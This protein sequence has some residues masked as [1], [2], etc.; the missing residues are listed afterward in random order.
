M[1]QFSFNGIGVSFGATTI[2][3][4]VTF[5]VAAG[6]KW[7]VIGRNGSGKT[8]LFRLLTSEQ[9]P[10]TGTIARTPGLRFALLDQ[11]RE[12][13]GATTVWGAVAD[14]FR[15][16]IDLEGDLARQ[17]DAL[18][19]AGDNVTGQQLD[20]YARDLERFEHA[21]GY[22]Y[23]SRVDAVLSG[24]GFDPDAA[25]HEAVSHLSGGERGRVALAR[26]LVIPADVML[27]DEPTNHLDLETTRWLEEYLRNTNETVLV[28]SHDRA[29]LDRVVDHVL[30]LEDLTA[31]SYAGGYAHFVR[32]R[33]ERR[34]SQQRAFD[35]QAKAIA[36]EEDY[37]RRNIAGTNSRQAKG[38]RRRLEW[39][40]RL[41]PPPDDET[42]MAVRFPAGERGG[43]QVAVFEH[44]TVTIGDRVLLRD[45][46]E[47]IRRGDVVGL[48]G[49]NGSGKST[50][51]KA[52]FG[53][54]QLAS[55]EIRLGGGIAATMYRQDFANVPRDKS[56]YDIIADLRPS[57]ERGAVQGHLGMV[58]FSGDEVM[59]SA[60]SLS[61]GELAR[62]ALAM[63]ML[64]GANLLVFDEP[65]N[66][67]DVESIEQLEDA[68][69]GF[70]GT[71]V[72]VSH[73]RELLRKLVTRV[74]ELR[75]GR[76]RIFDGDYVEF[77]ELRERE[78]TARAARQ[79]SVAAER[80]AQEKA[81]ARKRAASESKGRGNAR[82]IR[83]SAERAETRVT[84]LERQVAELDAALADPALYNDA[85]GHAHA[86]AL[87][88]ELAE[89]HAALAEALATWEDAL[90]AAE[91]LDAAT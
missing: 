6:E 71:V 2:L 11:H 62:V 74:W 25:R 60:S 45:F 72:L 77:E 52:L 10:T 80:K 23:A 47:W 86:A 58:Q 67:L 57:W 50:L 19:H 13:A 66:H 51:L 59:R 53:E 69:E 87:S 44:V 37:I 18:A 28:I 43:D 16:L 90:A 91:A 39:L 73:D 40:P 38:R 8:T 41:S 27:L 49:P 1:T 33:A 78:E 36:K 83:R 76:I 31:S 4:D 14:A 63:M 84:D 68:I 70:P 88:R 3:R 32:Q 30:H 7:G 55:G 56:L 61:G 20:R 46:S 75:D 26:Q 81:D 48:I 22:T 9:S 29:F 82:D 35:R 54:R 24:L 65:T 85:N 12:F 34:L 42:A 89:A 64:Q 21:G 79:A 17:A 15:D 5:T